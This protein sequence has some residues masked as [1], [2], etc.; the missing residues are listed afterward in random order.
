ML[1][2]PVCGN[3]PNKATSCCGGEATCHG[4][5]DNSDRSTLPAQCCDRGQPSY[6][7]A[8]FQPMAAPEA[9]TWPVGVPHEAQAGAG[10]VSPIVWNDYVRALLKI[11]IRPVYTLTSVYRI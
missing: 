7:V 3:L 11:P 8:H 9:M 4:A 1:W 10:T 2:P 6:P 5:N